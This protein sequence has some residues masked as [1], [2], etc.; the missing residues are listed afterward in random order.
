MIGTT[1]T[2]TTTITTTS[3]TTTSNTATTIITNFS[4]IG[5]TVTVAQ[6]NFYSLVYRGRSS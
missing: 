6:F 5:T 2:T 4:T 1:T 3:S